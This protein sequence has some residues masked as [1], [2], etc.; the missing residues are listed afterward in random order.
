M[1]SGVGGVGGGFREEERDI[2]HWRHCHTMSSFAEKGKEAIRRPRK[3][4][5][6]CYWLF[7]VGSGRGG[8]I[9]WVFPSCSSKVSALILVHPV[10]RRKRIVQ[11]S[12]APLRR[13]CMIGQR[14]LSLASHIS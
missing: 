13:A 7:G 3:W 1:V 8:R 4:D 5:D 2:C 14:A 12:R 10:C 9:G 6:A 11:D